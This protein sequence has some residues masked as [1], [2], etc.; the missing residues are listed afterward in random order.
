[1]VFALLTICLVSK[2]V[3]AQNTTGT[4]TGRLTDATGAVVAGAKVTVENMG[5]SETRTLTT[6]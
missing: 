2:R 5:T 1:M 6:D 3:D 4:I